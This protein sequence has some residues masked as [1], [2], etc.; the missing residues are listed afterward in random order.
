MLIVLLHG[1]CPPREETDDVVG[2]SSS[3]HFLVQL[4]VAI[5]LL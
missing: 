2:S 4:P 3:S 5:L 1:E